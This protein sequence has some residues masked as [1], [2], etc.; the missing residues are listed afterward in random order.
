[1]KRWVETRGVHRLPEPKDEQDRVQQLIDLLSPQE[2]SLETELERL[3]YKHGKAAVAAAAKKATKPNKRKDMERD[4]RRIL[5]GLLKREAE[6][7]LG[8]LPTLSNGALADAAL[9]LVSHTCQPSG[10]RRLMDRMADGW[11]QRIQ[12]ILKIELS[13][14][15]HPCSVL[16]A[17]CEEGL[18]I[19]GVEDVAASYLDEIR[20]AIADL[21]AAGTPVKSDMTLLEL[22]ELARKTRLYPKGFPTLLSAACLANDRQRSDPK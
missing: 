17:A 3:V 2:A 11:R 1:M 19:N 15:N 6:K 14:I 9:P 5:G 18:A 8:G 13:A 16:I 4:D 7:E 21:D 20:K 12:A 10:L 22:R